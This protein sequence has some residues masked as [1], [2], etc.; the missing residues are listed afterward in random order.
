V[1]VGRYLLIA[2]WLTA[3]LIAGKQPLVGQENSMTADQIVSKYVIAIGGTDKI[4]GI[5]T[6][7]ERGEISGDL[8]AFGQLFGPPTG[9]SEKATFEFYFKAPNLRSYLL[10]TP[11]RNVLTMRGYTGTLAWYIGL[12]PGGS[13]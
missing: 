5:T 13:V 2:C 3:S 1:N 11:N 6:F 4:A 10:Y 9:Q 12:C 7:S 8:A